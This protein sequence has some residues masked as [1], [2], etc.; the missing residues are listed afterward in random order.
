MLIVY[1]KGKVWN[2]IYQLLQKFEL[3]AVM[4][5]DSDFSEELLSKCVKIVV[6]PWVSSQHWIYQKYKRKICW[7]MDM[8]YDLLH[9]NWYLNNFEFIWITWT[10]GKSTT[11]W[12]VYNLLK[13]LYNWILKSLWIDAHV[14]IWWNYDMPLSEIVWEIFER[15]DFDK[16]HVVVVEVSSFMWYNIRNIEFGWSIFTNFQK[17]HLNWHIDMIEYFNS[18]MNLL[19]N[20]TNSCIVNPDIDLKWEIPDYKVIK[21]DKNVKYECNFLWSHNMQNISASFDFIR[22]YMKQK[23]FSITDAHLLEIMKDIYP[24]PHRIQLVRELDWIK[25]YDDWKS[26]TAQ[27]LNAAISSFDRKIILIAGWSDK[28]DDFS[29]LSNEFKNYLWWAVFMWQTKELLSQVAIWSN[30]KFVKVESMKDAVLSAMKLAKEN[31]IDVILFS[32]GCASFDMFKNR[33]DRVNQ[34]LET[35]NSL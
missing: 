2:S 22:D 26:T 9:Q 5:D 8:V 29:V 19:K 27:S 12:I 24:L 10:D 7:E 14:W 23:W 25:V 33:E 13:S 6:S 1:W 31:S 18:K 20:T 16:K 28:W 4:M 17:D 21:F 11:T 15:S 35:V 3:D 32:P 30:V 34:F